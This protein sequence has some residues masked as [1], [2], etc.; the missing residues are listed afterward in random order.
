ML[1]CHECSIWFDYFLFHYVFGDGIAIGYVSVEL[2]MC[3]ACDLDVD[4]KVLLI[5]IGGV[6]SLVLLEDFELGMSCIVWFLSFRLYCVEVFLF[7]PSVLNW[8]CMGIRNFFILNVFSI[9]FCLKSILHLSK[10]RKFLFRQKKC[11]EVEIL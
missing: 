8:V 10:C 9:W 4:L 11:K 5:F 6:M 2:L 3:M 1:L 7:N